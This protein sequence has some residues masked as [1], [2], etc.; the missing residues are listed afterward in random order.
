MYLRKRPKVAA[1]HLF[2]LLIPHWSALSHKTTAVIAKEAG[3][4]GFKNSEQSYAQ[5]KI[6]DFIDMEEREKYLLGNN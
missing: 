6:K 3:K 5:S 2:F 1:R 4:C